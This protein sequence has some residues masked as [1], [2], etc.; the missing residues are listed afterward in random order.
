M[1]QNKAIGVLMCFVK[2]GDDLEQY[3]NF[4]KPTKKAGEQVCDFDLYARPNKEGNRYFNQ[5]TA[6]RI[7]PC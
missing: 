5:L 2:E 1:P 7:T 4:R 6:W 3:M